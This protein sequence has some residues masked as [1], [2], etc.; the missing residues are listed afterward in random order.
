VKHHRHASP[1]HSGSKCIQIVGQ[2]IPIRVSNADAHQLVAIDKD[3]QYCPKKVWKAYHAAHPGQ[4][5][6]RHKLVPH[7]GKLMKMVPDV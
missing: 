2:G 1:R 4:F 5:A 3:G 7:M 6:V